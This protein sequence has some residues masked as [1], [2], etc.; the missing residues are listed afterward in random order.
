MSVRA[1]PTD[2]TCGG[3]IPRL[4]YV[5]D[6]RCTV[7]KDQIAISISGHRV[8]RQ[9]TTTE[10]ILDRYIGRGMKFETVITRSRFAFS[11]GERVLFI[12]LWMQ[13]NRKVLAH[14]AKTFGQEVVRRRAH[15]TPIPLFDG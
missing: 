15:D 9:V 8:D 4:I 13:K 3:Q 10:I 2:A 6:L 12:R 7:P 14:L 5:C 1:P 11:S